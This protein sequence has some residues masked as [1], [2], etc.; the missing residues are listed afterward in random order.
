MATLAEAGRHS[1]GGGLYL[2]VDKSGAKRWAFIYRW[3]RRGEPG[4]GRLREM[5]LGSLNAV[6]L[7]DAR[8]LAADARSALSKRVDPI[9]AKRMR[10]GVPTFGDMADDV[11]ATKEAEFR[12][13]ASL[14]RAKRALQVYAAKLRPMSVDV[15]D[16][17]AV[18][19][20]LKPIWAE[21]PETATGVRGYIEAVL[22][23]A[24][25]KGYRTGE[26]PAAW[27][28]HLDH[29]LP[30]PQ[31][32]TRGHHPALPY[33]QMPAFMEALRQRTGKTAR[34]LEFLILTAVRT[35][36]ARGATWG[37]VDLDQGLWTV[38]GARM[39]RKHGQEHIDHRVPLSARAIEVLR[40]VRPEKADSK[41]LVFPSDA[42]RE[43]SENAL[44]ALLGRMQGS[45]EPKWLDDKG[46]P[47][48]PH[49]FRASFRDWAGDETGFPREVTE[50]A[51][52]H[53][54][55]DETERAYRRSDALAKRRQLM[56]AWA[57]YCEPACHDNVVPI[58][59]AA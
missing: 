30:K 26:N 54:V 18:L 7:K 39:K 59:G 58:T 1:D 33:H 25:A 5:G 47:I 20:V 38:P 48:V 27:K 22:N 6:S 50:A 40:A 37:E 13:P 53:V 14:L 55:G 56:D 45:G 51:L 8:A 43:L 24:K 28:G 11:L 29:L 52:A 42:G 41:A 57:R 15:V 9:A 19:D 35:A 31:K 34:A 23:A 3:K 12:N 17:A 32:L 4:P 21:K 46:Q 16:T 36:A 49:G 2:V 10:D 44:T